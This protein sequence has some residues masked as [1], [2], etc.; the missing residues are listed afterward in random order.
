MGSYLDLLLILLFF[1]LGYLTHRTVKVPPH[2][3][4]RI[5]KAVIYFIF[6]A[7]ILLNIPRLEFHRDFLFLM[8]APWLVVGFCAAVLLVVNR[9]ARWTPEILCACLVL[10]PLGNT[11]NLG[12]PMLSAFFSVE[13]ASM[14]II[15]DQLGSFIGLCT[16]AS[17]L[18]SLYSSQASFSWAGVARRV[19]RFPPFVTLLIALVIPESF[20]VEPLRQFLHLLGYCIV[21][22]TMFGIGLQFSFRSGGDTRAP[23]IWALALKMV[24]APLVVLAAGLALTIPEEMLEVAVFQAAMPPMVAG[25]VLLI[26]QGLAPK[27]AVSLLG[28]GTLIAMGYLPLLAWLLNYY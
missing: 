20:L 16:Y 5:N 24:A 9:R 17:I 3:P 6:P 12:F 10:A 23:L 21:P 1:G 18:I 25:V 11:G 4:Q 2:L 14:G 22:L 28:F 7:V 27:F 8:A 26:A 19:F 15:F 13:Q